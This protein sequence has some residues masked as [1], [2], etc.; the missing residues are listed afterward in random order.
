MTANNFSCD[1]YVTRTQIGNIAYHPVGHYWEFYLSILFFCQI[2]VTHLKSKRPQV[3]YTGAQISTDFQI[4]QGTR[5]IA[6]AMAARRHPHFVLS[7]WSWTL[8]FGR[9]RIS[10]HIP[11]VWLRE[12]IKFLSIPC[13]IS[14]ADD[15]EWGRNPQESLN[16]LGPS[17]CRGT[18]SLYHK[19][20]A[21]YATALAYCFR[22]M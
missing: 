9:S 14:E 15:H 16:H 2:T 8:N 20:K 10:L 5:I 11:I 3:P 7:T 6:P 12:I 13:L 21:L 1:Q 4:W 19:I 17:A 18:V 22:F